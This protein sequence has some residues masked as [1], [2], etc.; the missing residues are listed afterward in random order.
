[1]TNL[2]EARMLVRDPEHELT[3]H[4]PEVLHAAALELVGEAVLMLARIGD[5]GSRVG[6]EQLEQWMSTHD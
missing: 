5:I 3:D 2:Q 1:M 6:A 4:E